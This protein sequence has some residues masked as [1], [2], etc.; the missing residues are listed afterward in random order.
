MRLEVSEWGGY[1]EDLD[2]E[3]RFGKM[4]WR[5][6]SRDKGLGFYFKYWRSILF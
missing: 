3:E 1:G 5:F 6:E 2:V 4:L